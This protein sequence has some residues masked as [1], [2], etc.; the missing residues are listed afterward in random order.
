MVHGITE[1]MASVPAAELLPGYQGGGL[2]RDV[3]DVLSPRYMDGDAHLLHL[4]FRSWI[5]RTP[6]HVVLIDSCIGNDKERPSF[7]P[8]HRLRTD[9]LPQ[10]AA[11]GLAPED[12]DFVCC[13]H[14]HADH[15]GWNT[16]L[17]DGRWVPTF[18]NAR[19]LFS[20]KELDYWTR[21]APGTMGPHDGVYQDSV[22]PVIEAGKA[23]IV[24]DGWQVDEH[25]LVRPAPGHT[26]G[27]YA[28]Q[29]GH[30]QG[31][32]AG[33]LF[34]GDVVHHP[35]QV[36]RP[37]W[38]SAFCQLPDVAVQTRRALLEEAAR[39]RLM[40]FPAHFAQSGFGTVAAC[41]D[42]LRFVPFE[43]QALP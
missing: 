36:A 16:R 9:F 2:P 38:N 26:E 25:L 42:G 20:Q 37:E 17:V 7:P 15:C 35:V 31:G 41:A 22:L 28:I 11:L 3:L 10:L 34:C 39:D 43:S 30:A 33:G 27:H 32:G 29:L 13:T 8:F 4:C 23:Q 5:V 24:E 40:L 14:L 6:R 18:P 21:Q 19:Y 1:S 12:I